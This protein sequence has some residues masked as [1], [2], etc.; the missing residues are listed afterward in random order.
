MMGGGFGGYANSTVTCTN[1]SI[2]ICPSESMNSPQYPFPSGTAYY[3]RTNYMGNYGGPGVIS[4]MS[5]TII[6][7]NN[8]M[9]GTALNLASN[10][11]GLNLYGNSTW[12]PV[13]IASITDGTSN[14]GL[15]SERMMGIAGTY[16]QT[17]AAAG[18]NAPRCA[19][20]S[21]TGAPWAR[22]RS[23]P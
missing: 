23:A 16:P 12:A 18:S 8:W 17:V 4:M 20:H 22:D 7:A 19:I 11:A 6:P 5:G 2:L 14:T 13:K 3:G 9:I 10:S 1:L 21:P 15:I